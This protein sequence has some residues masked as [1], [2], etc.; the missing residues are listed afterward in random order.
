MREI[1]I[2]W[3]QT[4]REIEEKKTTSKKPEKRENANTRE[5]AQRRREGSRP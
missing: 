4:N 3:I 5:N 1:P 2:A